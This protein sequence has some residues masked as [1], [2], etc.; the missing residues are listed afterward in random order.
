MT[1]FLSNISTHPIPLMSHFM[2]HM[3]STG[4][5]KKYVEEL[6]ITMTGVQVKYACNSLEVQGMGWLVQ[7]TFMCVQFSIDRSLNTVYYNASFVFCS[8]HTSYFWWGG[9]LGESS[10]L[11]VLTFPP[12]SIWWSVYFVLSLLS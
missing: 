3:L 12:I 6:L 9:W 5:V 1:V 4:Y 11:P 2:L 10:H 7:C 8:P